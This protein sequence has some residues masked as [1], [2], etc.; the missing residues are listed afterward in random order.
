MST[1]IAESIA[2]PDFDMHFTSAGD[3][4]P[5]LLLHGYV[6]SWRSW[7]L[8]LPALAKHHHCLAVD[9]RAHGLS[10][11]AGKQLNLETLA[12]DAEFFLEAVG[13]HRAAVIGHSMGSVV[14]RRLAMARPD[15]VEKLVLVGTGPT[16]NNPVVQELEAEVRAFEAE[17][18]EP[19]VRAFQESCVH[20]L[21][22]VP[23][24]FFEEQVAVS[25]RLSPRTWKAGAAMMLA[26]RGLG[27]AGEIRCPTLVIGGRHDVVFSEAEQREVARAIPGAR[28]ALWDDCGHSPHWE[29]P[30]RFAVEVNR[31]LRE[32]AAA[33]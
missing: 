11:Y 1:F 16:L 13:V 9:Q 4:P 14:A 8:V 6:D 19:F 3:G 2:L 29:Q 7:S 20:D 25:Q 5:V 31:F 24:D 30:A 15:L 23:H 32:R 22:T 33:A 10:R 12:D 27:R 21:N 18:P 26:D 17:A 28:L